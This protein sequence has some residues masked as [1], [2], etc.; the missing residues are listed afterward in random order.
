MA[1]WTVGQSMWG[2]NQQTPGFSQKTL[3]FKQSA[4]Q[5]LHEVMNSRHIS[6]S[7]SISISIYIYIYLHIY[8]SSYNIYI[9]TFTVCRP[10]LA[11]FKGWFL[12]RGRQVTTS[13]SR[14]VL[15]RFAAPSG[16]PVQPDHL[17]QQMEQFGRFHHQSH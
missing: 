4:N 5:M 14:I 1:R 16:V 8:I 11:S 7:I 15:S 12:H 3:G 10:C 13:F 2:F 9:Y 6:M 17:C